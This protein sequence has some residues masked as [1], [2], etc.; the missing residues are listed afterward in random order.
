MTALHD[1]LGYRPVVQSAIRE[2]VCRQLRAVVNAPDR[3]ELAEFRIMGPGVER[4]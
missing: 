3:P 1:R 2:L 4:C